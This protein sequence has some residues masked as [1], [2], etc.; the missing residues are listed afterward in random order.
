MRL[1]SRI[2]KRSAAALQAVYLASLKLHYPNCLRRFRW[3]VLDHPPYSLDLEPTTDF[4]V[5]GPLKKHLRGFFSVTINT[6][7]EK[8]ALAPGLNPGPWFYV[9]SALTIE[10]RR[11][12]IHSTGSNSPPPV[13]FPSRPDSKRAPEWLPGDDQVWDTVRLTCLQ[14][15]TTNY[16]GL[17]PSHT[18][19]PE[20]E[21]YLHS[22]QAADLLL[23]Y[24]GETDK[25]L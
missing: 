6:R 18:L 8:F 17:Y 20:D 1:Q 15:V 12:P 25:N 5:F 4:H 22:N 3:E 16:R 13:F 21:Y 11:S 23:S 7:G 24:V 10:L 2:P 14:V 19:R 9:P